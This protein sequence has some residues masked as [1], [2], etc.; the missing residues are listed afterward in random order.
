MKNVYDVLKQKEAEYSTAISDFRRSQERV[1]ALGKD[2]E[3]IRTVVKML[4]DAQDETAHTQ[5]KALSQPQMVRA[6]LV[7]SNEEMHLSEIVKAVERKFARKLNLAV[8]GAVIF[9]YAKRGSTFYKSQKR[10]NTW[11]LLEWQTKQPETLLDLVK[12]VQ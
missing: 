11:G 3:A 6:V 9:R 10:P 4:A 1:N 7:D 12:Q 5:E 8:T 2:I